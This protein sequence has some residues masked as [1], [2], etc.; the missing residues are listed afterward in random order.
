MKMTKSFRLL[1]ACIALLSLL[2]SQLAIA[3]YACP[4]LGPANPVV[5]SVAIDPAMPQ[6]QGMEH[7]T[8]AS[9]LCA[10]H[11]D[12]PPQF[13][14][15]PATPAPAP[16]IQAALSVVLVASEAAQAGA[17][18]VPAADALRTGAPPLIIRNCCFRI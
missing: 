14:D 10:A 3:A 8:Q 5:R 6:C 18:R 1:A 4:A 2:L 15:T 7:D 12:Y 17:A 16:F 13:A 11:C 9:A